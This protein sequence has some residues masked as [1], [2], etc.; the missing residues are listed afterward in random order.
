MTGQ[1]KPKRVSKAAMLREWKRLE[2]EAAQPHGLDPKLAVLIDQ[3]TLAGEHAEAVRAFMREVFTAGNVT[4]ERAVRNQR[5]GVAGLAGFAVSRGLPLQ[6]EVV[7]TTALIDEFTRVGSAGASDAMRARRRSELLRMARAVNPGPAAPPALSSIPHQAIRPC[8]T[9]QEMVLIRRAARE[10]PTEAR[11]R[12]LCAVVALGAGAGADSVDLRHLHV[13]HVRDLGS[14][15][16]QVTFHQPRPRVVPVRVEYEALLAAAVAGRPAGH[17]LIGTK[18]DRRNT[19]SRVI[20]KAVLYGVPPIDQAR[21][22]ATWLADLMTD[23]VPLGVL[24]RAAGLQSARSL[25]DLLPHVGPWLEHKGLPAVSTDY[26]VLR[27]GAR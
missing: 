1:A 20:D 3:Y 8:Y 14:R 25:A 15:G 6:L 13:G 17:L 19:A 21:L 11:V 27:G 5:A 2:A 7:M 18:L 22:R 12:G 9:P 16:W 26:E 10:Q 23:P 4:G 24:L